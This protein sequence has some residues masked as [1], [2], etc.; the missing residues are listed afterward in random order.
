MAKIYLIYNK[1]NG[2]KY[3]GETT[4]TAAQRFSEHIFHA[5][6]D[7]RREYEKTRNDFHKEMVDEGENIFKTFNFS[8]LEECDNKVRFERELYYIEKIKPEY[9]EIGKKYSIYKNKDKIIEEYKNGSNVTDI[10]KKY[11]CRHDVIAAILKGANIEIKRSRPH[12]CKKVYLFDENGFVIKEWV[13]AGECSEDLGI[14]RGNIRCCCIANTKNNYLYN[15][16]CGYH[17]K[18]TNNTPVDMFEI[19]NDKETIRF[20]SKNAFVNFFKNKFPEKN[21]YYGNLTRKRKTVYG[22]KIT[23]LSTLPRR[24]NKKIKKEE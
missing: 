14:D 11:K 10:R 6:K 3:V 8:I 9:N 22:Y 7:S 19:S 21:I 20:K 1:K 5:F 2:K 23:A 15:S 16:A 13:N 12:H 17:F 18:Y 4:R 24:K